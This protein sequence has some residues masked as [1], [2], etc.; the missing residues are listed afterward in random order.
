MLMNYRLFLGLVLSML[1]GAPCVEAS[2]TAAL[3]TSLPTE[4]V[5]TFRDGQ[6]ARFKTTPGTSLIVRDENTGVSYSFFSLI[7]DT[8][9][10]LEVRAIQGN[11]S[12]K[13][14]W[15]PLS[16]EDSAVL[17]GAKRASLRD[18][19]FTVD[20][21]SVHTD[22]SLASGQPSLRFL[23]NDG[24]CCVTCGARTVC[25]ASVTLTCGS[26]VAGEWEHSF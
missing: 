22:D 18:S 15:I 14:A 20:F 21:L 4:G 10:T 3:G 17:S 26:C 8:S 7:S 6:S 13:S 9:G 11:P 1:L 24:I 2:D 12:G 16:L 23:K 19:S 25:A 5:V